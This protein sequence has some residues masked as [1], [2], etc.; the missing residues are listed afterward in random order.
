MTTVHRT[1]LALLFPS[2][3]GWMA[4]VWNGPLLSQIT[5]GYKTHDSVAAA[6]GDAIETVNVQ[7]NMP[8]L[9]TQ[10]ELVS[11]LQ[12]FAEGGGDDFLDIEIADQSLTKFQRQVVRCCRKIPYGQTVTYSQLASQTGSP[13]A[14]R[15]VGSV[16][17][18][19][20][21][22]LVVPC[23]RVVGA[24]G[25][26]GGFSAPDGVRMKQ[27]LLNLERAS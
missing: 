2:A 7:A 27:H 18:A 17:A 12:T 21:F 20:R 22:P 5:F 10:N 3:L 26:L 4:T 16:M 13:R 9:A 1:N 24:N 15:A 11:R 14:A 25:R 8:K 23:H 19:N 6:I